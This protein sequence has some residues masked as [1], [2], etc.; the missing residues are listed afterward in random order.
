MITTIEAEMSFV[1]LH[2]ELNQIFTLDTSSLTMQEFYVQFHIVDLLT[3][4]LVES[5]QCV[6]YQGS[7]VG[8]SL[9]TSRGGKQLVQ[10]TWL[11]KHGT[12]RD[13]NSQTLTIPTC[14]CRYPRW[15]A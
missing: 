10:T 5:S 14:V 9:T 8:L 6:Q 13:L 4:E 7:S 2:P 15:K 3:G 11:D 1:A 12:L